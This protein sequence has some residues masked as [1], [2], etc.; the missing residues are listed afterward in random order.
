MSTYPNFRHMEK[1]YGD[2]LLAVDTFRVF[3]CINIDRVT[4]KRPTKQYFPH[5]YFTVKFFPTAHSLASF[6][7]SVPG[8]TV[9]ERFV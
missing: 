1:E 6:G 5:I 2:G 4:K 9:W 3:L 8:N 7:M